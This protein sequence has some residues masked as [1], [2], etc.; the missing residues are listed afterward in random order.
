MRIAFVGIEKNWKDLEDKDY[1]NKFVKYHLELPWYFAEFG[2]N[3]VWV[4]SE[5]DLLTTRRVW[6][7]SCWNKPLSFPSGGSIRCI[8]P[9]EFKLRSEFIDVVVHWRKWFDEFYRDGKN[10]INSQDH[11]YS[12]EW[13]NTVRR[14][15]EDNKLDG[16]LCFPKWHEENLKREI[17]F[18]DDKK[19]ISGLTLGVDTE[20]YCPKR[21]KNKFDLLWASDPGRGINGV[22]ELIIK[23]FQRDK[24][25]KLHICWPDYH[26]GNMNISHPAIQFHK[27]LDNGPALWDLFNTCGFLPYT[28][29][30]REPSSRAHRQAMAAGCVVLYPENM[31][32]PSD[33]I[34]NGVDGIVGG[35]IDDWVEKIIEYANDDE[36]YE[37][38]SMNA[39]ALAFHE[40]WEVQAKRFNEYFG[41]EHSD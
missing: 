9:M 25:F 4:V 6:T 26:S 5:F 10:V 27:N 37:L 31:G 28:S 20:I 24:R 39:R 8:R 34:T 19:F 13:L 32:T 18:L 16:I 1:T 36:T 38:M 3:D 11:S 15:D 14:A 40:N 23:L 12:Q 35:S 22:I 21:P 41:S 17:H 29:T 30:F 33:L 7:N 2:G